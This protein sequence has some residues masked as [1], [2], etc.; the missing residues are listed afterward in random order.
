MPI[1]ST[2][3]VY[4][5]TFRL[6]VEYID[7]ILICKVIIMWYTVQQGESLFSI[8]QRFGVTVQQITAANQLTGTSLTAGQRLF[9]PIYPSRVI[10]YTVQPGDTLF[11]I[12]QRFNTTVR[13]ITT[14]NNLTGTAL[15]V[16][17][18]LVIPQYTEAVVTVDRA[19]IR[20]GPGEN[21][22]TLTTMVRGTRLPVTSTTGDWFRIRL[23][24]ENP[25]WISDTVS[26]FRT[27]DGSR[28]IQGIVGFYTLEEGPG[29]PSSF[30]S[31]VDNTAQLSEVPLFFYRFNRED[32]TQIE[33]FG[34]FT[35]QDVRTLVA[36]GHRN[37]IK[38]M[39]VVHNLLYRPGGQEAG[40]E[41][42]SR[43]LATPET[44]SAA[45]R[46]ILQLIEQFNFDGVNIDIEDVRQEDSAR[47]SAFYTELGRA[48]RERGFYLSGS[49][50]ARIGDEP[51]NPFSDPFD[52][53]VIGAA[54]DQFIVMLYNEHGWPGSP[55]GPAV[56]AGW[57]N[58]VLGYTMTVVPRSKIVA[59][60]SIFGFDFN[61]TTGRN[62]YASYQAAINLAQRYNSNIIF[63]EASL[64]PYFR[65]TAENGDRHEVW[66]ENQFSTTAK[67]RLAWQHGIA[68]VALWRLGMEEPA[69]WARI[70]REIVVRKF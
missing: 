4:I 51:F 54:V 42:V 36:I 24:N 20:S 6:T 37:N 40:R 25:G 69:T 49:I 47:L 39:P 14:L 61:L 60:I 21:F 3:C 43:M 63:D 5:R 59:A 53:R 66:F 55:P 17:Q 46:N 22:T 11:S 62:T 38:M 45:I 41:V 56:S 13:S 30:R 23:Y 19:N 10:T 34:D 18:R 68:G 28:P 50:P 26:D 27:Y 15:N 12:A 52:Y 35:D 70:A 44:R 29:L 67:I 2:P 31:F 48:M 32:P 16:G 1:S 7:C 57:M 9:I 8:A 33:K 64:T 65:Y 58:R